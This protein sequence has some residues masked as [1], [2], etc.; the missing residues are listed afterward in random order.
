MIPPVASKDFDFHGNIYRVFA[1]GTAECIECRN[2]IPQPDTK[3]TREGH[4]N[5]WA[6]QRG[7]RRI[8]ALT[9]KLCIIM[10]ELEMEARERLEGVQS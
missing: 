4:S 6:N 10:G 8:S 5:V 9:Q 1:D 2:T 3:L 7:E